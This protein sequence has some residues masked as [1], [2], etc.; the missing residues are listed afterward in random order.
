VITADDPGAPGPRAVLERHLEFCRSTT[1]AEDV[2]ALDLDG[3][4]APDV[5]FF[6]L[7]IDGE[8]LAVGALKELGDGHAE[9]KSMHTA[10]EA[11]GRG[12]GE[13]MVAHLVDVARERGLTRISLETGSGDAFAAPRRLYA[14]AGFVPCGPFA[15]YPESPNS[16]WMTLTL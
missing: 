14:R 13:R 8:V 15:D 1:A 16:T 6:S 7:T 9:I 12:L 5:T 4:R 3:L 11:R 10:A 2:H